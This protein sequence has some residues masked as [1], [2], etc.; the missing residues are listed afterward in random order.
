MIRV[1]VVSFVLV[2][3]V[4]VFVV[5]QILREEKRA[6]INGFN[7]RG[8]VIEVYMPDNTMGD[9]K[10]MKLSDGKS[11]TVPDEMLRKVKVGDS[12]IKLINQ[13]YLTWKSNNVEHSIPL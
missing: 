7:T 4:A 6:F 1:L 10:I 8:V 5:I 12:V 9:Y 2:A 11:L 3:S 13:P